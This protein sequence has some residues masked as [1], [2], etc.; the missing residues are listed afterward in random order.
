MSPNLETSFWS[1]VGLPEEAR[2]ACIRAIEPLYPDSRVGEFSDQGYCSYT[3]DIQPFEAQSNTSPNSPGYIVQIRPRQHSIDI[4]I[5]DAARRTY[6]NLAP[7]LRQ[8]PCILPGDLVAV[9]MHRLPGVPLSKLCIQQGTREQH[10]TLV[11][12]LAK[13]IAMAYPTSTDLTTDRYVPIS[14]RQ[15][16]HR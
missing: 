3:L 8:L 9:E 4:T 14:T 7:K 12:S 11:R 13:T 6:G 10:L 1:R 5:A 15:F 2:D 16:S